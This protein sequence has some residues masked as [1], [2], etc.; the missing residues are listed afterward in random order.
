MPFARSG[1]IAP[2]PALARN[3]AVSVAPD[4][5]ACAFATLISDG[6]APLAASRVV[7]NIPVIFAANPPIPPIFFMPLAAFAA[8]D[9]ATPISSAPTLIFILS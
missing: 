5:T 2:S 6:E 1:P 9:P 3:R 7:L 8:I 4:T